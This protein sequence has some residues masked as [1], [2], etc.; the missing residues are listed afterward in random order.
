MGLTMKE[1][2]AVAAVKAAAYGKAAKKGKGEILDQ[3][4]EL[5][6]Y[7]RRYAARLLRSHNKKTKIGKL[8]VA[9]D[10]RK[11]DSFSRQPTYGPEVVQVLKQ[12]WIVLDCICGKRLQP[13]LASVIPVLKAHREIQ[14]SAATETKLLKISAASIDR[15]LAPERSKL[16]L[17][18]RSATKPGT[19]LKHQIPIRTF[20]QWNENQPGF[21]EI[22]LVGH[23]GGDGSG[24]FC[25]SLDV[26]DV[27][28]GW[29][30]TRA[31]KNKAQVW[32]FAALTEIRQALPFQLL[33]IDSDNGGEFINHEL[34]RY[35]IRERITFTR[36]RASRKND[37]CFVEEKN[38]S[39]VRRNVGYRRYDTPEQQDVLNQ[40]YAVLRLYTNF[41]LPTMKLKKKERLGSKVKK[42]YEPPLT[43]Y[44][45]LLASPTVRRADKNQLRRTYQALNPAELK[46]QISQLQEELV[47][48]TEPR[49]QPSRNLGVVRPA[50]TP[51]K[52]QRQPSPVG[53]QE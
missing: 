27:C 19:L 35:C 4:I 29:T 47:Q 41:F 51:K 36:S 12:I 17:K 24:D 40:L 2:R 39:V 43:P 48:L 14:L 28:T 42:S 25:Q 7:A 34:F 16:A 18:G 46:R 8:T 31:V 9:A 3:F 1:K 50:P 22:D 33:G 37:N 45:R 21:V 15:L 32:V 52:N 30:E 23:D 49:T 26:T 38:Y 6:G 44:Q 13:A 5:T 53:A 11:H 10:L 20:S